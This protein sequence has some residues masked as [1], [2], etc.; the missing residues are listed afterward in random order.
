MS[1][2]SHGDPCTSYYFQGNDRLCMLIRAP[3]GITR[4]TRFQGVTLHQAREINQNHRAIFGL[5][6][7]PVRLP[8]FFVL[9]PPRTG[10]S[11]LHRVLSSRTTLPSPVK[12]TRFFDAHFHRGVEWYR[13]HFHSRE[14]AHRVGEVAP[15]YFASGDARER[16]SNTLP[17]AKVVCIFRNP[18]ER[19]L[20]LYRVKRAYGWIRLPLEEA[21]H[22]DPE[23]IESSRYAKNLKAWQIALGKTQVLPTVYDDLRDHPQPF[24]DSI[25]DFIGIPRFTLSHTETASEFSS[26]ALTEPRN[27]Y[28]T[29][30]A[31]LMAEWFKARKLGAIP[32]AVKNSPLLK[33]FVGGG[34]PFREAPQ[35][36]LVHLHELFRPEIDELEVLLNRELSFWRS[37]GPKDK[38]TG[39]I[40]QSCR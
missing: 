23:L 25:A 8:S 10:T 1:E 33:M 28:R 22:Q 15:T 34:T 4:T 13:G 9:G 7:E 17:D 27:Y 32:M 31:T 18:V 29:R 6:G 19:L 40:L 14:S 30:S 21:I 38:S 35:E 39:K 2:H 26:D 37:P 5:C 24:V 20:S 11:W 36:L 3:R 12:E 16:I